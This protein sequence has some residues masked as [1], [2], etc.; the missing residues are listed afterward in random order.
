M[1]LFKI[2]P[3]FID[4]GRITV[5][6]DD[7]IHIKKVLRKGAGDLLYFTDSRNI[8]KARIEKIESRRIICLITEKKEITAPGTVALDLYIAL[9]QFSRFEQ[10]LNDATQLGVRAIYP[11]RTEYTQNYAIP[12]D[13]FKRWEKII[14]EAANQSFNPVPPILDQRVREL[15]QTSQTGK[16]KILLYPQAEE[17][18]KQVLSRSTDREISLYIGPEAGFSPKEMEWARS[19]Q[20]HTARL[21]GL[22][23]RAE[24]AVVSAISSILFYFN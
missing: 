1:H 24:T 13:K 19:R 16:T 20:F 12:P 11:V 10:M 23:M 21:P 6:K 3:G 9:I 22:I 4:N 15:D 17:S 5:E 2:E 14:Q 7:L 8:Y 18:L